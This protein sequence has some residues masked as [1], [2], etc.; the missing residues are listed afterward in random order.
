MMTEDQSQAIAL[1]AN[2]AS[3]GH[4][5][6]VERIETHISIIFLVGDRA[7][8]MKKALELPYVD[9]STAKIRYDACRE[10]VALNRET[11]PGLYVGVRVSRG[12]TLVRWSSMEKDRS[13][14]ASWR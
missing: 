11:A 9:F 4:A 7:Y 8:K 14:I 12:L 13:S 6:L 3:Y 10:E 2:S 1:L 5:G